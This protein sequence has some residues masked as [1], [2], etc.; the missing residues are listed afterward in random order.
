MNEGGTPAADVLAELDRRRATEPDVHGGRLFGL[1]YPSG[2]TDLED[3]AHSVYERYLFGNALNPFKFPEL[4]A[5]EG[6]VVSMVG[7]LV[8]LAQGGL[9]EGGG[10]SMTSGGTES[11]LMSMLVSRERA[12]ARGIERPQILAPFSAH[13]AYAKAAHY[14]DLDLVSIPL[15]DAYRADLRAAERLVGPQTAVVIASAFSYPHGVMDP[16]TELAALAA[17]HGA[18]CH[19]DAC[20]GA[21]VLPFLERIGRDVP[22]WDFRVPGVTEMSADVHKYGYVPKGA[23]VVLH[24]DNDWFGHQAFLYDRWPAGLYGSPA[25]AGAR[26]AAPIATAW[27][28]MTYLGAEGYDAIV[29]DLMATVDK[30]RA[31]VAAIGGIDVAGEP[32]GPVLAFHS[33]RVD[34]AAVG[35]VMDERGWNLNRNNDPPGLHL[36]LSP[37]HAAVA[38]QLLADLADAVANHGESKGVEV[39]Y[40]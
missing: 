33:D 32:I 29:R 3:L 34:L 16:V 38:D 26:P 14:F 12:R 40:S 8:H 35:D 31:G 23:S 27:A 13:P 30:V 15:D 39:R 37:A 36:M 28:V 17:E 19:V 7:S 22:P 1:T 25:I 18:G 20:I 6:D 21:F 2:R 11:I 4:A 24:R 9:P 5:L 10:G